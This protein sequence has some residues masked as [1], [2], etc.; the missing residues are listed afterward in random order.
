MSKI[1]LTS[2]IHLFDYTGRNPSNRFRLYQSR[3]ISQNIIEVGKQEGCDYL[4]LAG[5]IVER[6]I[7]PGYIQLEVKKF[8]DAVCANF[9]NVFIIW[10]QHDLSLIHI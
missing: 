9:K 1:L 2:D 3:I 4:V 6:P 8:L 10:G 5:D 7:M